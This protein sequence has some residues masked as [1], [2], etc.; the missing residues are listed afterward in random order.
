MDFRKTLMIC[1]LIMALSGITF[2]AEKHTRTAKNST[3]D[4]LSTIVFIM[5]GMSEA[6]KTGNDKLMECPDKKAATE[7]IRETASKCNDSILKMMEIITQSPE[8][9]GDKD[10]TDKAQ[11]SVKDVEDKLAD[12][13]NAIEEWSDAHGLSEKEKN[14]L[15]AIIEKAF[16]N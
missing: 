13:K 8:L 11:S 14:D 9:A 10:F 3:K 2:A 7:V 6:L 16:S 12:F 4:T 15:K 5:Q 1:G